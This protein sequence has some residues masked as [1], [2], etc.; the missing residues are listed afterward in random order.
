[1]IRIKL[2]SKFVNKFPR[3]IIAVIIV[4]TIVFG[5]FAAGID[6]Q[7]DLAG[8]IPSSH[9]RLKEYLEFMEEYGSNRA[10]VVVASSDDIFAP[11][12]MQTIDRITNSL[13]DLPFVV[14]VSSLTNLVDMKGTPE[15]LA[16][17]PIIPELPQSQAEADL[18]REGI[19][20]NPWYS[21]NVVSADGKSTLILVNLE[22]ISVFEES[23]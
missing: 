13:T 19:L 12:S 4:A 22:Y 3:L 16:S 7:S 17:G 21:G 10:V 2:L 5:V 18:L 20:P 6:R 9:P 11:Q 15:G 23:K 8:S 14:S 1:M